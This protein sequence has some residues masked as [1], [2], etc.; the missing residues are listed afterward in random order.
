MDIYY[1]NNLLMHHKVAYSI[2]Y[3]HLYQDLFSKLSVSYYLIKLYKVLIGAPV[4][5]FTVSSDTSLSDQAVPAISKCIQGLPCTNS[6]IN[7]P[8]VIEPACLLPALAKSAT[9][10][11][12]N[13]L[14]SSNEGNCQNFSSVAL[15]A[16]INLP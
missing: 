4:A 9:L 14:Y 10:P 5:P 12:Y 3:L 1:L 11:L 8:A 13:S 6:P 15:E 16:S 7:I 2:Y